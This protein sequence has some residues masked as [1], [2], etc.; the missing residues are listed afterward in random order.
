MPRK[1]T[2]D[3]VAK[4]KKTPAP[5]T[6]KLATSEATEVIPATKAPNVVALQPKPPERRLV[7]ND[8]FSG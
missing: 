6:K 1:R 3:S 4:P 2:T 7:F 5:Q 8:G